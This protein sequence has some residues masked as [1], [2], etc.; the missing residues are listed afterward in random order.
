MITQ[1]AISSG[2]DS[3]NLT[4][5]PSLI[6]EGHRR[7]LDGEAEL[8]RAALRGIAALNED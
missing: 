1:Q 6:C 2:E 4:R 3:R 5:G 8:A 7:W